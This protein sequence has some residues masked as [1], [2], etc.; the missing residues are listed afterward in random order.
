MFAA[1]RPARLAPFVV[2][3]DSP[4]FV[5]RVTSFERILDYLSYVKVPKQCPVCGTKH[6]ARHTSKAV[7]EA[8]KTLP[9][10]RAMIFRCGHGHKFAV[11]RSDLDARR[12]QRKN[13]WDNRLKET[14]DPPPAAQDQKFFHSPVPSQFR[15][16]ILRDFD[17]KKF[18]RWYGA[19]AMLF[20][21]GHN[22]QGAFIVYDGEI[23][24]S[25]TSSEG[26]ALILWI[27]EPGEILGLICAFSGT[28]YEFTAEAMR[29]SQVAFIPRAELLRYVSQHSELYQAVIQ[30]IGA[31]YRVTYEQLRNFGL[32]ASAP[33]RLAKLLLNFALRTQRT[34]N[35]S[36]IR[37][38]W[39]HEMMAELVGTTRETV[40][41]ILNEFKNDRLIDLH[42][43]TLV[44]KDRRALE[45]LAQRE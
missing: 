40:T 2:R 4:A 1:I 34:V 6:I 33:R 21:E 31:Q 35:R 9:L 22:C 28:P 14:G 26:R 7:K 30:E 11:D 24:L 20:M 45:E 37:L 12:F 5:T 43:S 27:A 13:K 41:R 25:M 39:T 36:R 15:Q 44:I 19:G 10:G 16:K 23:K 38:P 17:T 18:T 42:R 29:P 32:G 3:L 8:A